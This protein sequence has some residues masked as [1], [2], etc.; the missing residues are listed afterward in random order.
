M[1]TKQQIK[2]KVKIIISK[3][4]IHKMKMKLTTEWQIIS[5]SAD[6]TAMNRARLEFGGVLVQT[7]YRYGKPYTRAMS[8]TEFNLKKSQ[9][10]L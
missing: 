9:G 2:D 1:E 10:E 3:N 7:I 6:D 8:E 5:V 4:I